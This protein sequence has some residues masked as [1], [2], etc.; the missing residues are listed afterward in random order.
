MTESQP[1]WWPEL[2]SIPAGMAETVRGWLPRATLETYQQFLN[3]MYHYTLGSEARLR[4]AAT[5]TDDAQ[6]RAFYLELAED[7]APHFTLAERDLAFFAQ[8]PSTATPAEVERFQN[9]WATVEPQTSA[10]HL[11][12]L[13]ALESVASHAAS[14]AVQ[15]LGRLGLGPHNASFVLVHLEADEEHGGL[16]REHSLRVGNADPTHLLAGA[17]E[18]ADAWVEM[19]RCLGG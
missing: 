10:A 15:G 9:F 17:R 7:E 2:A 11:G 18:A 4:T 14:A 3:M 5:L 13:F 6:L 12:A 1:V 8:K 19:H 16:C